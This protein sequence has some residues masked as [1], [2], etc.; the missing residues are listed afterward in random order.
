MQ[1][2]Y[3]GA[4]TPD[5]TLGIPDHFEVNLGGTF[6]IW[7][8]LAGTLYLPHGPE[9]FPLGLDREEHREYT[10]VLRLYLLPFAKIAKRVSVAPKKR[11]A[12]RRTS[13]RDQR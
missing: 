4:S 11:V 7:D 1:S 8:R 9:A 5:E 12:G 3:L 13:Y 2:A 6:T 10:S